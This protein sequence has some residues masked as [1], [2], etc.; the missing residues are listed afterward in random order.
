MSLSWDIQTGGGGS[1]EPPEPTL[2]P[3]LIVRSLGVLKCK[4]KYGNLSYL[5]TVQSLYNT[6]C[7]L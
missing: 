1:S 6:P 7:Y 3:P 4:G 2:D 5:S